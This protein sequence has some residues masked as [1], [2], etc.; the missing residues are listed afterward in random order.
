MQNVIFTIKEMQEFHSIDGDLDDYLPQETNPEHENYGINM[1][2][3]K[4]N[5]WAA[6]PQCLSIVS[7]K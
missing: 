7:V 2:D 6:L 1:K 5:P 3:W 4:Q